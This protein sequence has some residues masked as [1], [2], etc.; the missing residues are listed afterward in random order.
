MSSF[1]FRHKLVPAPNVN[2]YYSS[3]LNAMHRL[4]HRYIFS[5][6]LVNQKVKQ[7]KVCQSALIPPDVEEL[8]AFK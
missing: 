5:L 8:Y 1:R 6:F 3:Y 2:I 4:M 7:E